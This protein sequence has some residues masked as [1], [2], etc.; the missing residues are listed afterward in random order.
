MAINPIVS[1]IVTAIVPEVSIFQSLTQAK[2]L[3]L[4][5]VFLRQGGTNFPS[6]KQALQW[7]R[8]EG[9]GVRTTDFYAE[10]RYYKNLPKMRDAIKRTPKGKLISERSMRVTRVPMKKKYEYIGKITYINKEDGAFTKQYISFQSNELKKPE[11]A[12][13]R[14]KEIADQGVD[15]YNIKSI[16]DVTFEDAYRSPE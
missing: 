6:G 11:V 8:D 14:L 5:R 1:S 10:W 9:L 12:Q 3:N 7:L 13:R 2:K 4:I 16:V 15:T